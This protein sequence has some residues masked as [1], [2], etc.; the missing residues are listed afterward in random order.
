MGDV[1][2]LLDDLVG[3]LRVEYKTGCLNAAVVGGFDR[4]MLHLIEVAR[5]AAPDDHPAV[6]H[7]ERLQA[8]FEEY[9]T[10][11]F[12]TREQ[13]L[14][15][16]KRR[17]DHLLG[18][19]PA[20]PRPAVR[21]EPV[22]VPPEPRERPPGE[23]H[24]PVQY[25]KG[26]GPQRARLL[27]RLRIETVGDLLFH[28]P[29]RHEDRSLMAK[30]A[31][32]PLN[33]MATF[34]GRVRQVEERRPRPSLSLTKAWV[35]DETGSLNL[36][37]FNQP[38]VKEQLSEGQ[39]LIFS[40]RVTTDRVG[41]RQ[42][43]QPAWEPLEATGETLHT[44]RWV[45][46]YPLTE[47]IP[48]TTMRRWVKGALDLYADQ[49]PEVLP[50]TLREDLSLVGRTAAL[51]SYHFPSSEV[52]RDL[53]RR[54][55]VF[56]EFFGL[57]TALAQR[58]YEHDHRA[59]GI[60]FHTDSELVRRLRAFLPFEFTA[61]QDRV[62]G[63]IRED[64]ASRQ[65][66][67][68][69]VQGDVGSGKTLVALSA[70]LTVV[71]DGYQAALM[72]PTEILAEQHHRVIRHYCE[73]LGVSVELVSGRAGAKQRRETGGRLRSGDTQ[74]AVGTHALIQ[75]G[76]DFDALGLVVIDEQHRFG[77]EQRQLLTAK[78]EQ[79][80]VL[81]MTATPIP[82]TLA[83]TVYG[84][85]DVS[86]IDEMPPGRQP[87]RTEWVPLGHR[88]QLYRQIKGRL[89]EGRQAFF[90]CPLVEESDSLADVEAATKLAEHLTEH[91]GG[92]RVG[93]IHGRLKSAEKDGVMEA[94]RAGELDLLAATTVIEVGID[95]PNAT[96][97]VIVNA[98][99]F[100]LAQLHQL[101]GRVGRGVHESDCW[102]LTDAK[103]NPELM[104]DES[105][106]Q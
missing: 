89:R 47:G 45:P 17:L 10:L 54:R 2:R 66:M 41:R 98:D 87:I 28:F 59:P 50:V 97:M 95:V 96:V 101:R 75:Q 91:F 26:V 70:M 12:P 92:F 39:A 106:L 84:D 8:I 24:S 25:L 102:L 64:L 35:T 4:H 38:W 103:Y 94:F 3:P 37:W 29:R 74:I 80:D 79:P 13:R 105:G 53:A 16:A 62:L 36:V 21:L 31:H 20:Q 57:Q 55:L 14:K 77:V 90:V 56:E 46:L 34:Q 52:D 42:I 23:L 69:L 67:N 82:R 33:E 32:A 6:P 72:V 100:G 43:V 99:R 9:L 61:A 1:E 73:P 51:R 27:A 44:G 81:V 40:G 19:A 104:D 68:R 30:I 71:D 86:T 48:Q 88:A 18:T 15:E 5:T 76:V 93:L 22:A 11:D 85:L 78:G 58:R 83:L 65:P 49:V 63:E 60:A 7:L